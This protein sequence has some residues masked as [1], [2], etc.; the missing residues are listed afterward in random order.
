FLGLTAGAAGAALLPRPP[1]PAAAAPTAARPRTFL[2][3]VL[4]GGIDPVLATDPKDREQVAPDVDV[5]YPARAVIERGGRRFGPALG[6][7][8]S[9]VETL[10]VV[11]GVRIY[12]ASHPAALRRL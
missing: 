1:R 11:R 12:S 5:P 9:L 6:V 2:Q 4:R 8:G 3:I 10:T 7:L